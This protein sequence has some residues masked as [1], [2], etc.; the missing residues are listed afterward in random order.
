[1]GTMDQDQTET[2]K[3]QPSETLDASTTAIS[4]TTVD[5][6]ETNANS[7]AACL[8][9]ALTCLPLSMD[10]TDSVDALVRELSCDKTLEQLA[11][12]ASWHEAGRTSLS[13]NASNRL[14]SNCT[15]VDAPESASEVVMLA[16]TESGVPTPP[17]NCTVTTTSSVTGDYHPGKLMP[18]FM[19]PEPQEGNTEYKLKLVNPTADR[20]VHLTTQMKWRLAEGDGEAVYE[21]G[22]ADDGSMTGVSQQDMESS[23]QTLRTIAGNL[24]AHVTVL[25]SRMPVAGFGCV[26]EVHVRRVPDDQQFI[27]IRVAMLGSA[28]A[29]KSTLLAVLTTGECDNGKGRARLNLFRHRH[30]I[31]SGHTSSIGCVLENWLNSLH[32]S[33]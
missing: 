24:G 9:T 28:Q 23:L 27:D 25:R 5:I 17:S 32:F 30:E 7:A 10:S 2:N 8:Q 6:V 19:P 13:R 22:V 26:A 12:Q 11:S 29:G 20:I 16:D 18:D 3:M 33:H 14:D 1:L 15:Q 21:I 31:E 4:S